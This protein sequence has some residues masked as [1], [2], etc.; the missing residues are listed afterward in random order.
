M[1]VCMF[2]YGK[3]LHALTNNVCCCTV[4]FISSMCSQLWNVCIVHFVTVSTGFHTGGYTRITGGYTRI[5]GGYTS[6]IGGIH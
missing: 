5:T 1:H 3:A 6:I 4:G 2:G